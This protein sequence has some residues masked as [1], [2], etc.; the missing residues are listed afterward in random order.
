MLAPET[1]LLL[2]DAL[3]PPPGTAVA[4]AVATTY[5]LDLIALLL[6][7][8]TFALH[9]DSVR[10]LDRV[11][12]IKLLEA[13]RR[14]AEHTTVFTQAGRIH[15]PSS[16]RS[17]LTFTED[18]TREVL[19]PRAGRVFHAKAWVVRFDGPGLEPH[20]RVLCASRNL[21]FDR[22]WDTLLVLDELAPE[23][24]GPSL[25]GGPL[26]RFLRELPALAV[27]PLPVHRRE[28]LE[29]LADGVAAAR[30]AL[31]DGFDSGHFLPLG[32]PWSS[33]FPDLACDRAL[34]VSP[35]LD[36]QTVRRLSGSAEQT[37]LLSRPE[38]LDRVGQAA[39][40]EAEAYVL[41]RAAEREVGEDLDEAPAAGM[42]LEVPE[43]LH[44]KTWVLEDADVVTVVTGSANATGAG[45]GLDG[46]VELDVVL[47]APRAAAGVSTV[48]DGTKE[49]PGLSRLA[50]PYSPSGEP[51][52]PAPDEASAWQIDE[53][54]AAL[55][56]ARPR[57][58]VVHLD[59]G[60]FELT[61][62]VTGVVSPGTSILRPI[63]LDEDGW[64]KP[65][66]PEVVWGPV[67]MRAVTPYF[68]VRTVVGAGAARASAE[69]VIT[70]ELVG[71]PEARR[72]DALADVLRTRADVL[73]YLAFLLG[74]ST[75]TSWVQGGTGEWTPGGRP[76]GTYDDVVVFEPLLAALAQ[77]GRGLDRVASLYAELRQ[78]DNAPELV[79]EGWEELWDAVWQAHLT[80]SDA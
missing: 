30:L 22:S 38:S 54:H 78:L 56:A 11:D 8:M 52:A 73:R 17:I 79:P 57:A 61:W 36:V 10:D 20:H 55:A 53:F 72:R 5:S 6:A 33:P 77:G 67:S 31:P 74:D 64:G 13:V 26:A 50:Q 68:A 39:V 4:A 7:P 43:G 35:F 28:Q 18:C 47:T 12:P 34:V 15:V 24:D 3:R 23:Q 42:S 29:L 48:W 80:G 32:F 21:T 44:A 41:Q 1:R 37:V 9:D 66:A 19:P 2:T 46:N 60:R 71:D 69:T 70:A 25:D 49:S 14:H 40:G 65:L 75:L 51:V 58:N 63:T 27:R 16:Y 59:D 76:G 62:S 45:T